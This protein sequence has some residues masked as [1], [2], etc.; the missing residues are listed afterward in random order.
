VKLS[1]EFIDTDGRPTVL[2]LARI[3]IDE[4]GTSPHPVLPPRIAIE[5][6]TAKVVKFPRKR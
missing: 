3:E 4:E 5:N 6:G 2:P 1:V